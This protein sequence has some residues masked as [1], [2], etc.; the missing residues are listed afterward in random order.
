MTNV[1]PVSQLFTAWKVS[2]YGYFSGLY[3]SAL[4]PNTG[5]YQLE[6]IP[7][8][9]T[10]H[11]VIA[12]KK[13]LK[14]CKIWKTR[15]MFAIG[16]STP[17][18]NLDLFHCSQCIQMKY[19]NMNFFRKSLRG[20]CPNT[21]FFLVRIL[22]HLDWIRRDTPYLSVFSL[23]AGGYGPEITQYLN[24]FHAENMTKSTGD[25]GSGQILWRNP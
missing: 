13:I 12:G 20:K 7:Y 18:D 25:Y 4:S 14:N 1:L 9:D 8:L 24:T 22:P 23:N 11:V 6:K 15:K 10:F 5:K 3:F 16:H 17:W 21:K 2:E 19:S